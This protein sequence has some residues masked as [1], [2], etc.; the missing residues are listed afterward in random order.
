MRHPFHPL[1]L[2]VQSVGCK[3]AGCKSIY[4]PLEKSFTPIIP[5]PTRFYS[6]CFHNHRPIA[7]EYTHMCGHFSL[8]TI[9]FRDSVQFW[10][11]KFGDFVRFSQNKFGEK[12]NALV[13]HMTDFCQTVSMSFFSPLRCT[14]LS[15]SHWLFFI[16]GTL[17]VSLFRHRT[18]L[19]LY[20][21]TEIQPLRGCKK[22]VLY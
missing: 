10:W 15:K 19:R 7:H 20:G 3:S 6:P 1:R 9:R 8:Y 4:L 11:N 22:S 13:Q 2:H 12:H 21:V 5:R 14:S 18:A 16:F 17:G